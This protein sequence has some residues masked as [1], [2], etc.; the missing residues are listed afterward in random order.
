[1]KYWDPN[2]NKFMEEGDEEKERIKEEYEKLRPI[3]EKIKNISP[4][5]YIKWLAT[6]ITTDFTPKDSL[7]PIRDMETAK[8]QSAMSQKE[9]VIFVAMWEQFVIKIQVIED[10]SIVESVI[11]E[12]KNHPNPIGYLLST[13]KLPYNPYLLKDMMHACYF[14]KTIDA[15]YTNNEMKLINLVA[16]EMCISEVEK[17]KLI[18]EVNEEYI[19]YRNRI[20][21]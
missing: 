2:R 1:M 14:S 8:K 21:A 11:E 12:V 19:C 9:A 20:D 4:I 18:K 16:K 6:T 7:K 17:E 10:K 3:R 13:C 15:Y 5:N